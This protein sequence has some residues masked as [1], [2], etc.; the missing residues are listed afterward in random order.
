MLIGREKI[1]GMIPHSGTMQLLDG[2]LSWDA[3][4]IRCF[5]RTHQDERNPLRCGAEL[6]ALC[7]I[8]YAAQAMALHGSLTG[9]AGGK[10]RAGYLASLR[11]VVCRR[12]R[13]DDLE[14][15]LIVE[16]EKL[17]GEESRV[18]YGFEVRVGESRVLCGRA[19]VVLDADRVKT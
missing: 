15:E 2:V 18:I 12:R 3:A 4:R 11:D 5:S 1:A 16:A 7:G 10:P 19:A 8:E 14:G 13:I 6:P 9:H 17:M